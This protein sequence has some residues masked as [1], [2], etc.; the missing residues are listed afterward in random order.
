MASVRYRLN[1]GEEMRFLVPPS[2]G[3][4]DFVMSLALAVRAASSSRPAPMG[5]LL[6]APPDIDATRLVMRREKIQPL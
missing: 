3:H 6:R 2:E 1:Q 5:M 4:D